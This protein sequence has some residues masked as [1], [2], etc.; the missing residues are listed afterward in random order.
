MG[1][2]STCAEQFPGPWS[3]IKGGISLDY[4]LWWPLRVLSSR[5]LKHCPQSTLRPAQRKLQGFGPFES[6][7]V[8][9]LEHLSLTLLLHGSPPPP[10]SLLAACLVTVMEAKMVFSAQ[11][12][13]VVFF[14][15]PDGSHWS[16]YTLISQP[17]LSDGL[18]FKPPGT[19]CPLSNIYL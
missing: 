6:F 11:G 2:R 17:E 10:P 14:F 3:R 18:T 9:A 8:Q 7:K 5:Y 19:C 12:F 16:Y 15:L 4:S 13:L 1:L